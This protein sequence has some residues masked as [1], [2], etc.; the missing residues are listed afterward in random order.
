MP[1]SSLLGLYV[2]VSWLKITSIFIIMLYN[3]RF[4][5]EV[6]K[7]EA[8]SWCVSIEKLPIDP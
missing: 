1:E 7:I 3:N 4:S 5:H 8:N 6:I 2:N